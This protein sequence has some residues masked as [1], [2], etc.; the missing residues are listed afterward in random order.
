MALEYIHRNARNNAIIS[1]KLTREVIMIKLKYILLTLF[2][3]LCSIN[4]ALAK[5][6]KIGMSIDDLRLERW[7]KDS[8]IFSSEAEK[9]GATVF[10]QSANGDERTQVS[11]IENMINRGV[12]VLVIIPYNGNVLSNVIAEAKR[13]GIPVLAYDRLINN[14][15]I[16]FYISFDNEKVGELQAQYILDRVPQG[17][18]FLM[19]GS[20]VDNNAK[21]FRQGQMNVLQPHIDSGEIQIVG[22]QWVDSWLAENA[23]KIMEAALTANNNRI[24]AVVAS[25]DATAGGAIQALAAQGLA[26]KVAISGQDADLAGIKR[27]AIGTQ[28]M[29]VYKPLKALATQAANI[30]V[31]LAKGDIPLSNATLNNGLKE[32]PAYLLTPIAID[33]TNIE[34][35]VIADGHHTKEAIYH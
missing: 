3:L 15:D 6:I 10:V 18:Y 26:G 24:D 16:D 13:E 33:Q 29:T 5:N 31:S 19:G 30:A 4:P 22:D 35:T 11:Q 8:R 25:N 12:D 34:Q 7:Q 1:I 14:A 21:L 27:I 28:T 9:L 32:V 23:L 2:T 20:P 17:R